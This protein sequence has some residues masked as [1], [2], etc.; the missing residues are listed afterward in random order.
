MLNCNVKSK[1]RIAKL[2]L[3]INLNKVQAGGKK[4]TRRSLVKMLKI[5]DE[6]AYTLLGLTQLS[7]LG[8]FTY[9]DNMTISN[10]V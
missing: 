7:S 3:F 10:K 9:K 4:V 6:N 1:D 2:S 5:I 8:N